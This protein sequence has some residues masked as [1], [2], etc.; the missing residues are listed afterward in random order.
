MKKKELEQKIAYLESV[1]DQLSAEVAYIDQLMKLIGFVG[2]V[3]TVKAT[4]T[5]IIKK[6]Y[7]IN[8]FPE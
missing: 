7:T 6:G 4:A 5:E 2:G 3:E 1:N 8:N